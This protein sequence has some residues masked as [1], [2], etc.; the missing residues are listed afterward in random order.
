[1]ADQIDIAALQQALNTAAASLGRLSGQSSAAGAAISSVGT[2]FSG[3]LKSV[4]QGMAQLRIEMDKGRV[5]YAQSAQGLRN[6]QS[7]FDSLSV[8]AQSSAAGQRIA[9]EQTRMSGEL[10]RR[11]VGE[12]A[13]DIT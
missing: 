13:A 2:Q 6:L 5:G 9:A 8:Q 1:M 7:S 4:G 12:I 10:L 3:S 11:G